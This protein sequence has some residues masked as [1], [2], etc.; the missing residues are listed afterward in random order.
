MKNI[1]E[2]FEAKRDKQMFIGML[3]FTLFFAGLLAWR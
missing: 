3:L 1:N 2:Y